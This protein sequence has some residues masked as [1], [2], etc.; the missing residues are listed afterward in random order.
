M[1]LLQDGDTPLWAAARECRLEV[2]R[3]LVEKGAEVD[4]TNNVRRKGGGPPSGGW[5]ENATLF[6]RPV[7]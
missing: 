4:R 2:V 1:F 3:L 6:I 7:K 5:E